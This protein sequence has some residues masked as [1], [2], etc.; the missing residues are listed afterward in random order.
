MMKMFNIILGAAMISLGA[1][2]AETQ[3]AQVQGQAQPV[4]G[5]VKAA[6]LNVRVKPGPRFSAVSKLKRGDDVAALRQVK[7]WYEIVLPADASVWVAASQLKDGKTISESQ[8]RAGPGVDYE[9]YVSTIPAGIEVNVL[10]KS[11]PGWVKIAAPSTLTGWVSKEY[12]SVSAEDA[13][14]LESDAAKPGDAK[15]AKIAKNT[16]KNDAGNNAAVKPDDKKAKIADK[17][18]TSSKEKT[19]PFIADS[20]KN[21]TLDGAV[22]PLDKKDAVYVTHALFKQQKDGNLVPVCY[23]HSSKQSLA[24]WNEKSVQIKGKQRKVRGWKMPVVEVEKVT[25]QL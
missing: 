6:T 7:D 1:A 9:A 15:D 17:D 5:T 19:L 22:Y 4:K 8:L 25:P 23:L 20:D 12:I 11:K 10:D 21:V 13:K 24:P 16:D 18:K 2:G 3:K 14:K